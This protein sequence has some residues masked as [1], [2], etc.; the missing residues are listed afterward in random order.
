MD[1]EVSTHVCVLGGIHFASCF[2]GFLMIFW[3]CS[4]GV[5]FLS[6]P[7]DNDIQFQTRQKFSIVVSVSFGNSTMVARQI[8][9]QYTKFYKYWKSH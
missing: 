7:I 3:I 4:D 2:F 6:Q 9:S 1:A 8:V 5:V